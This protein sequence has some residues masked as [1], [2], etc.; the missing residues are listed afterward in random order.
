M[1]R[2]EPDPIVDGLIVM[3]V[4]FIVAVAVVALIIWALT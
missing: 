1:S 4:V 2:R 3:S